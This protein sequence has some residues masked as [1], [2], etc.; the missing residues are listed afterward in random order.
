[1]QQDNGV[2]GSASAPATKRS[3][4]PKSNMVLDI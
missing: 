4:Y 2:A 3:R 1:M